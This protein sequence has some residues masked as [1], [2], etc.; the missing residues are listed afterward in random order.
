MNIPSIITAGDSIS[1]D[2][3][4]TTDNLG[5]RISSVD[6]TLTYALRGP[7]NLSVNAV[8]NGSGWR[9]TFTAV[10]TATLSQEGYYFYQAYATK[11]SERVTLGTGRVEV[12]K[13]L[14]A[15]TQANYDGRS[16]LRKDY[17]AIDAAIRSMI[18]GGAVQSYQ[19]GQRQLS[20]IALPDLIQL[21]SKIKQELVRE[22][23]AQKIA[24]GKG[25]PNNLFVRFK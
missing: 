3:S 19:I 12:K 8:S 2:D 17:D 10:Q 11:A 9:T 25:S 5:N 24:E 20:K 1:W 16:Q 7:V 22:E 6:W 4:E 21:R 14:A 23:T 18:S 15:V 13:N